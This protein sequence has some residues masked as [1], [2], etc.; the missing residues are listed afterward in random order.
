MNIEKG[1]QLPPKKNGGNRRGGVSELFR[2]M[3][4]GDSVFFPGKIAATASEAKLAIRIF[5]RGNSAVRTVDGGIR[6][7]RLK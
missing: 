3:E 1:I 2:T 6:V 4:V 5:G 7:W